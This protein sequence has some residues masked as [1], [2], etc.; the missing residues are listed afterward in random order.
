MSKWM[1]M[2]R[3][4]AGERHHES[5]EKYHEE[6]ERQSSFIGAAAL[7][8]GVIFVALAGAIFVGT[9]WWTMPNVV[10]VVTIFGLSVMFFTVSTIAERVLNIHKT[11]NACYLLGCSFLFF[12]VIA[13]GCFQ[14]LGPWFSDEGVGPHWWRVFSAGGFV[15]MAAMFWGIRR[16]S[17]R[18]YRQVCLW[19]V[20]V[21]AALLLKAFGCSG[22]G[23]V[24]GLS[25]YASLWMLL[26]LTKKPFGNYRLFAVMH[27]IIFTGILMV[28]CQGSFLFLLFDHSFADLSSVTGNLCSMTAAAAVGGVLAWKEERGLAKGIFQL[29]VLELIH[30]ST[31]G[32]PAVMGI[33]VEPD[34]SLMFMIALTA[35][36]FS[37]GRNVFPRLRCSIGDVLETAVLLSSVLLLAL[38]AVL[39]FRERRIQ[40]ELLVSVLLLTYVVREWGKSFAPARVILPLVLWGIVVPASFLLEEYVAVEDAA[41][42][43]TVGYGAALMAWDIVKRDVFGPG[44]GVIGGIMILMAAGG[45][46]PEM[47]CMWFFLLGLYALRFA[48]HVW[49][50]KPA[51][52]ASMMLL[53]A[54]YL[55]Q[56]WIQWPEIVE[57]EMLLLPVAGN[58]YGLGRIWKQSRGAKSLQTIGYTVCLLIL[59]I[60]AVITGELADALI[61]EGTCLVIFLLAHI[62]GSRRWVR[63]SGGFLVTVALYMTKDFWLS[64]AWWVYLLAA[65]IGLILFAAVRERNRGREEEQG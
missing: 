15:M 49:Y 57:L 65:G 43:L 32:I 48:E 20:T 51:L 29:M 16:F 31:V 19:S 61:L 45:S 53:T 36:F 14:L 35:V 62:A 39:C 7:V 64:I 47:E 3:R 60:D 13:A 28:Q 55:H 58:I 18:C 50:R 22:A 8:I 27:F 38:L 10:K 23:I 6:R 21:N 5:Q 2:E 40:V 37:L 12:T 52:T 42:W 46:E 63:I 1:R 17:G 33:N 9:A 44:I 4:T 24:Q 41:K 25:L 34:Q 26:A 59:A 56:P 54:A 30:F 11:A